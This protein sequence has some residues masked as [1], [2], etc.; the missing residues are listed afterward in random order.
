MPDPDGISSRGL[1]ATEFAAILSHQVSLRGRLGRSIKFL[2]AL[3]D[4]ECHHR[5]NWAR[6]KLLADMAEQRTE[7]DRY[8]WLA[9]E[10][11]GHDIGVERAQS[12]WVDNHAAAWRMSRESFPQNGFAE[13]RGR[14]EFPEGLHVRLASRLVDI[15]N[16]F[17]CHVFVHNDSMQ[18]TTVV[19]NGSG[20]VNVKSLMGL[21][22]LGAIEGDELHFVAYGENTEEALCAIRDFIT[23][24]VKNS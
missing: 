16:D 6:E 18:S 4:F 2:E 19:V 5:E 11:Q 20:F 1:S 8:K 15:A 3:E 22:S 10:K 7:I 13:M 17:S 12:E 9:S 23:S 24:D 14:I 21:F